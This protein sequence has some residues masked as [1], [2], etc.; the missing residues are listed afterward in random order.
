M[1]Y[2]GPSLGSLW[3]TRQRTES[4]RARCMVAAHNSLSFCTT[5]A[6]WYMKCQLRNAWAGTKNFT[7]WLYARRLTQEYDGDLFDQARTRVWVT[8][9]DKRLLNHGF[10]PTGSCRLVTEIYF[11]GQTEV[12]P[13]LFSLSTDAQVTFNRRCMVNSHCLMGFR[14][15]QLGTLSM[16]L[17]D[18]RIGLVKAEDCTYHI[19]Q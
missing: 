3:Q 15:T 11:S 12:R 16:S 7:N 18:F 14:S 17:D 13:I 6:W 1:P 8:Q 19:D 9:F 4:W 5:R 10:V 2:A